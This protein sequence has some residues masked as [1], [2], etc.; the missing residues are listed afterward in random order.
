MKN[1]EEICRALLDGKEVID[2]YGNI[3]RINNF[4]NYSF[5]DPTEWKIYKQTQWKMEPAK[6]RITSSGNIC[7]DNSDVV[8]RLQYFGTIFHTK[9]QAEEASRQMRRANLL[10]YWVSTMQSLILGTHYLF[11][12]LDGTWDTATTGQRNTLDTVYMTEETAIKICD[13]L[14]SG[15]LKLDL[16]LK[17]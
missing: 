10:R 13:G 14:N 12:N 11:K 7:V 5:D 4:K 17:V 1:N 8:T 6:W 2:V 3:A 9:K 16:F 15:E